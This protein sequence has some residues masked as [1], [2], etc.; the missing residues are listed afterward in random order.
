MKKK[1]L[2]IILTLA[3]VLTMM[4]AMT[5]TAFADEKPT[6]WSILNSAVNGEGDYTTET[7][8]T[9]SAETPVNLF[10]VKDE[11]VESVT[12]R[13][14]TLL[15]DFK[16][17]ASD[18]YLYPN[19]AK[20]IILDL[21]GHVLD[22]G[23]IA[24]DGTTTTKNDGSAIFVNNK[25]LTLKDSNAATAHKFTVLDSG[26]WKY[27]GPWE[28][29]DVETETLKKVNG[30]VVTGGTGTFITKN[31]YRGGGIAV[32]SAGHFTMNG[33][34]VIG[35]FAIYGGGVAIVAQTTNTSGYFTMTNGKIMGNL[36]SLWAG[37]LGVMQP[38]SATF[39]AVNG[40]EIIITDNVALDAEGGAC[41]SDSHNIFKMEGK[42]II[43]DN[44][45]KNSAENKC[46]NNLA[47]GYYPIKVTGSLAG[48]EI[49]IE[50]FNSDNDVLN[51]GVLSSG[52]TTNNPGAKLNDIFHYDGPAGYV[53][54]LKEDGELESFTINVEKTKF[55]DVEVE[56][57]VYG[58]PE[59][60]RQLFDV[61]LN[62]DYPLDNFYVEWKTS[63]GT[64]SKN[65]PVT[66]LGLTGDGKVT[67]SAKTPAG[68]YVFRITTGAGASKEATLTIEKQDAV[69]WVTGGTSHVYDGNTKKITAKSYPNLNLDIS[70]YSVDNAG[71]VGDKVTEPKAAG[72]YLYVINLDS[73]E[74]NYSISDALDET[75]LEG[76]KVSELEGSNFGV[77]NIATPAPPEYT[78]TV[79][80]GANG[81]AL[82]S[83]EKTTAGSTV[84]LLAVPNAGYKFKEWKVTDPA[85]G[86]PAISGNAFTMPASNVT[87]EATW[88]AIPAPASEYTVT[89][90]PGEH[91]TAIADKGSA[92]EG[93]KVTLLA[94]PSDGYKFKEWKYTVA[95]ESE[96]TLSGN[97]YTMGKKN[98]TFTAIW[99]AIP[100]PATTYDI[101]V[102]TDEHGS[103]L[104]NYT[105]AAKDTVVSLLAVPDAGYE[106]DKWV[107]TDP[108]TGG[109]TVAN[110]SFTMPASKVTVKATFKAVT[111]EYTVTVN[112]GE[113]G[114]ATASTYKA[115]V[116]TVVKLKATA[117]S[118]YKFEAWKTDDAIIVG[119]A[120]TM[121]NSDVTIS[122]TWSKVAIAKVPVVIA[123]AETSGSKAIKLSWNKVDGATK[124][125][126]YGNICGKSF[127]K[128]KTTT[129][130][131]YTV[132]KIAGK[133]LAAH[134]SYKFYVVA[135]APD[136]KVASKKIHFITAN[137]KGKYANVKSIKAKT[138]SLEL[139]VGEFGKVGAT[140]KMY[141][142]KKHI[143]KEHGNALRYI[144]DCP[145][146]VS[147]S[148]TGKI[149]ARQAGTATIYIQDVGG[150]Y[151]KTTV[152]VK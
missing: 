53:M 131:T 58:T 72:D 40:D 143:G 68:D 108:S 137:T 151:C 7:T 80:P 79:N 128:L 141:S 133:K 73:S 11:T 84:R 90:N 17:G 49:Y 94:V 136:G 98:V 44:L 88:E 13:T 2:S 97:T 134:K 152:T 10:T 118:G 26:L 21:N 149:L 83:T 48:S 64:W 100:A 46:L 3:M 67:T 139:A 18:T 31:R 24:D 6:N 86:G 54:D 75:E 28:T 120:F 87:V 96:K 22:R 122:A 5:F 81:N 111:A 62:R 55:Q 78:V 129:G 56:N 135:Y 50:H 66:G 30:G 27:V 92:K 52:F 142:G 104:A 51:I 112:P 14:I 103:A 121:P 74:K 41:I 148:S 124:Y 65:A 125:V 61:T 39:K 12:T 117:N 126:V 132:K 63:D 19:S 102:T 95:G 47:V 115:E 105:K 59:A 70:Y 38:R 119:D 110:N 93:E 107:V 91:G 114:T 35:N 123:K 9:D 32:Y 130:K 43:K 25:T 144:S 116:G 99:E 57:P 23:L 16:A 145:E 45:S 8:V 140:Y 150:K 109:P 1:L 29:G 106:F 147:V 127:K 85:T 89:V 15:A 4:P 34:N 71:K 37:G 77:M 20:E 146:V 113:H 42:I 36:A 101:T 138:S 69:V 82:A 76:K 33:G 60:G